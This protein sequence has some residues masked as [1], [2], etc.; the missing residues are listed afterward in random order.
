MPELP[1]VETVRRIIEPQVVGQRIQSVRVLND[2]IIAHPTPDEFTQRL[3]GRTI[4]SMGRRG[5]FLLFNLD[6][7]DQLYLHLRMT[8]QLLVT[9]QD[10]PH[11]KHTHFMADLSGGKQIRFVDVRRFGRFWYFEKD[12]PD[13]V[14][15]IDKLGL[16]PD[17]PGLTAEYLTEKLGKRKKAIKEA[18]L[19]QSI[20]A[21]IG[22]IYADEIL[23]AC[24][25]HPEKK[26]SDL[27]R[28]EMILLAELI[29]EEIA[30][31]TDKNKTTPEEYLTGAGQD[32][33]NTPYLHV[34]GHA[35][36]PCPVCGAILEKTT[37]GGRTSVYCPKCQR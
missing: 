19:D 26:C 31:Y 8:G 22:N 36:K 4:T 5:K 2:Q 3:Q 33:Q 32:Y 10:Y 30:Y 1:E 9:P 25:I 24:G 15:G 28:G 20:V 29:P 27:T 37:I 7:G 35:G 21:G 11:E 23:F 13:T 18:L 14:T 17:D 6:N 12:E 34:Y 16:E